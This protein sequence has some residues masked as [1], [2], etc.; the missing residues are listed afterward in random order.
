MDESTKM[1]THADYWREPMPE[2]MAQR[3]MSEELFEFAVQQG[4]GYC[5]SR[6]R[7]AWDANDAE[8]FGAFKAAERVAIFRTMRHLGFRPETAEDSVI[9]RTPALVF[10]GIGQVCHET[11]TIRLKSHADAEVFLAASW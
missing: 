3:T 5:S 7:G 4:S 2:E 1:T 9:I 8:A 6:A 10:S 11:E